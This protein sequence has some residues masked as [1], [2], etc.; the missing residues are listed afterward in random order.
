MQHIL[1]FLRQ[2][3][4]LKTEQLALTK[5]GID[6]YCLS[7][8][9][10]ELV[11][12][13][14]H[15]LLYTAYSFDKMR[16]FSWAY[17]RVV[18]MI[19]TRGELLLDG[20]AIS[21]LAGAVVEEATQEFAV[22]GERVAFGQNSIRGIVHWLR[23]LYPAVVSGDRTRQRFR[24]RYFCPPPAFLWAVDF[25]YRVSGTLYG[26]RRFLSLQHIE[27]LCKLCVLDPS[28]LDNVL[29]ATKRISNYDRGGIFHYGTEGG[30]GRWLLLARPIPV[31]VLP[32]PD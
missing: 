9:Q 29:D 14:M 13:A 3:G 1:A 28:G 12:E 6:L 24:R 20:R 17:A 11:S 23:A 31:P 16:R 21:H 4:L 10:Q 27:E 32:E 22:A 8:Q 30:F 19:W 18:D 5:R 25:C 26:V 2:V 15:H 7:R